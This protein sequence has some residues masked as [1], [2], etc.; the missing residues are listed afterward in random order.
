MR[1]ERQLT[2]GM[3]PPLT[4]PCRCGGAYVVGRFAEHG[5][6]A[7][8]PRVARPVHH[9]HSRQTVRKVAVAYAI[10]SAQSDEN[11]DAE[12]YGSYRA[13]AR[14]HGTPVQS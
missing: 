14:A 11:E 7:S 1:T 8:G 4:H 10:R 6:I 3:A 9:R 2:F 13:Y 12:N 5:H